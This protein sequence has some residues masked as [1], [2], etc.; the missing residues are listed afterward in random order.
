MYV[1]SKMPPNNEDP[2][3]GG[4]RGGYK[5]ELAEVRVK[6][7]VSYEQEWILREWEEQLTG[8]GKELRRQA[9]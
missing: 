8:D 4:T 7:G 1:L 3:A 2:A 6:L 9:A 5:K